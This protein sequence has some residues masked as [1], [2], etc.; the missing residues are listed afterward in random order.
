[1]RAWAVLALSIVSTSACGRSSASSAPPPP[2]PPEA[3]SALDQATTVLST[4]EGVDAC[5]DTSQAQS[6][7]PAAP[8]VASIDAAPSASASASA[9]PPGAPAGPPSQLP[10]KTFGLKFDDGPLHF[11]P[12][13]DGSMRFS[14]WAGVMNF[15]RTEEK[16]TG[17][18]PHFTFFVNAVYYSTHPGHS[19]IGQAH[20]DA[21]VVVRRALTQEALNEGHDIGSHGVGHDDGRTWTKD[22][23][24]AEFSK[25]E[26]LMVTAL[27]QPIRDEDG[28]FVFPRFEP[29]E[30]A[31]DGEPGARCTSDDECGSK[32]CLAVSDHDS[33]CTVA[34]NMK[35]PCPE[36]LACGTPSFQEDTDVCLPPPKF[37]IE[38]QGKT[39]FFANGNP[40]FKHPALKPYRPIGFRAP[41]LASNDAMYS[42]LIEHGF[43]YDTSQGSIPRAPYGLIP[44]GEKKMML[45][46]ALMPHVG[47][48]SIPMDFNYRLLKV[49][50]ED[51]VTDYEHALVESYTN[52]RVPWNVGHH[53]A[54]W[55]DGAYLKALFE[56]V[57]FALDGCPSASGEQA[58]PGADVVSFRDLVG[59]MR[60]KGV[61]VGR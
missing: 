37:P 54:T 30:G 45:E 17:K 1:V 61:V 34:C 32:Q 60:S 59:I 58:C 55:D 19:E 18:R 39:L 24:N 16:R 41:F 36:G 25:F 13:F 4:E 8:S 3:P 23:W 47:A 5:V 27:F 50:R 21:E 35:K 33:F 28:R 51:M 46:F 29:K 26:D 53:F 2:E 31:K 6:S 52:G 56:T 43:I 10:E 20:S 44:D 7:A 11:S 57:S 49:S 38:Y 40:N 22:Q 15:A 42:A 9:L 14:L 48:K 12:A